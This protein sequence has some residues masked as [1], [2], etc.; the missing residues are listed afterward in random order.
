MQ[1]QHQRRGVERAVRRS[2]APRARRAAPRRWAVAQPPPR[3]LQHLAGAIDRDD[4]ARRTARARP[5]PGRCRSRDRRRSSVRRAVRQRLQVR[6]AAEQL[7]AQ[8]VPLAGAP[9]RRTPATC[10]WR[11]A[12]TPLAAAAR[13]GRRRGVRLT[14][15][16][17]SDQSRRVAGLALVERQ[18]VVAARRL[19]ARGDPARVRQRLEVPADRGLRQ[20]QDRA[21]LRR[22]SARGVPASAACG[23]GHRR[24]GA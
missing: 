22:P 15:S 20:L 18:R 19:A 21:Q 13:P 14:C 12:S 11:R 16:R 7:L 2:A 10:V 1:H 4:A 3:R 6:G 8:L 23:C 5:R 24:P 17:S 9:T